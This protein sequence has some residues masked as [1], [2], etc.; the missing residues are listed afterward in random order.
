MSGTGMAGAVPAWRRYDR[1]RRWPFLLL[2]GHCRLCGDR[3][4]GPELCRPCQSDLP[5]LLH[6]C[7]LCALPLPPAAGGEVCGRCRRRPPP[8]GGSHA[9]WHYEGGIAGLI[10]AFKFQGDL[11]A[12]RLLT[13]LAAPALAGRRAPPP[14]LVPVP[15]H[16]RRRRERGFDQALEIAR[17][18]GPPV[19]TDLVRRT[20]ETAAQSGLDAGARRRN[21]RGAFAVTGRPL[22]RQLTLVDDVLTTGASARE[23]ARTLRAAGVEHVELLVLA[24]A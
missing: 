7:R 23:L 24:R 1:R 5:W 8:L 21:V 6:A 13:D 10:R 4:P 18:L 17:G 11:A 14:V 22:P 12:G 15:L 20:R 16:P 3:A 19:A 2:A 9:V